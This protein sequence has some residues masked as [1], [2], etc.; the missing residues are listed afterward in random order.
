MRAAPRRPAMAFTFAAFCY[1]LSLV[2]C[3]ALIFFAIWHVSNRQRLLTLFLRPWPPPSPGP[4]ECRLTFSTSRVWAERRPAAAHPLPPPG[5]PGR[6]MVQSIPR[7]ARLRCLPTGGRRRDRRAAGQG[8]L[9]RAWPCVPGPGMSVY[10]PSNLPHHFPCPL[11][12][13]PRGGEGEAPPWARQ[14]V[15]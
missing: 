3:A 1:M 7:P 4:L 6:E 11:L 13:C 9:A 10:S 15:K 12:S 8:T 14:L 5:C 2:L